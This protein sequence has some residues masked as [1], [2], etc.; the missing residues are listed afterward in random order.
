MI[1]FLMEKLNIVSDNSHHYAL[2]CACDF[3]NQ[4]ADS[5]RESEK[6]DDFQSPEE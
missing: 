1:A 4:E 3:F 2:N 5:G 6:I